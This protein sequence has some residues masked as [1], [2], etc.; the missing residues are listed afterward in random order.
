MIK[1]FSMLA[2]AGLI[3]LP[4]MAAASAGKTPTDL[5]QKIDELSRQLDELRSQLARQN[6]DLAE[7]GDQVSD[8]DEMLMDKSEAWDLASRIRLYG[9]FRA[10]FDSMQSETVPQY[11]AFDVANGF[12]MALAAPPAM[13]G[14]GFPGPYSEE[15]VRMAVQGL[16]Q[17]TTAEQRAGLFGMM[18]FQ[19]NQKQSVDSDT[20]MT[21]RLRINMEVQATENVSFKSRLAMYKTWGMESNPAA[22]LGSPFTLDSFNWDGNSTRQPFDNVVRVDRAYFNWTN[23]ADQ[24][25]WLSVG[26]RPTTDGPPAHLRLNTERLATPI[27]FMDFAFDGATLGYAYQ[28]PGDNLGTGRIRFCYGRGFEDGLSTNNLNDMDF[29]GF[30]WDVLK[31]GDRFLNIQIFE[32]FNLV[33]TPDGIDYPNPLELAGILPQTGTPNILDKANLGN[34]YHSTIVYMDKISALNWFIAGGWSRTDPEGYDEAGN[35]LLTSWW[36]PL[37]EEDGFVVYAG[38]RYDLDDFRLK[39]GAEYNYG[40]QYWIG[41]TPGH[42]DLYNSKLATR[43]HVG[44]VYLI[45]D[46][47]T[48]EALSKYAKTFMRLGYQY[49]KYD[50]TY[51]G[52]WLGAPADVDELAADPLN[53][54]F[55]PALD[56][57]HQI[58]LTLEVFF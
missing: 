54:Q 37:D 55:Y 5:E 23:I 19:P 33:N 8:M 21:N 11:S 51:S 35:G 36:N 15:M 47:P 24:P 9:D 56:D 20:L 41:M 17:S 57:Q 40:S 52:S 3:A 32:A 26:R 29:A 44:E 13:G 6:E 39:L 45:Y 18:G 38:A 31:K 16:Q 27:S 49:Y 7:V 42:D 4:G 50:Y 53:A 14:F 58:Y 2:L 43:G 1:K 46:L 12:S 10:R 34:I 30:N 25:I 48:G 28:W 22:T